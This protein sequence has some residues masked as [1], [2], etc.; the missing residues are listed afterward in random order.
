MRADKTWRFHCVE[1]GERRKGSKLCGGA[2][3]LD[4]SKSKEYRAN[5]PGRMK[6]KMKG[7]RERI[8]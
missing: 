1:T 4:L 2:V 7:G 8:I 6:R 3:S 5:C